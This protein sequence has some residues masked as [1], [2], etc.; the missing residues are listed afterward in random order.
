MKNKRRHRVK[1]AEILSP[2]FQ[3][4][5][6]VMKEMREYTNRYFSAKLLKERDLWEAIKNPSLIM[7][8]GE[9][10]VFNSP[11][12]ENIISDKE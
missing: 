3:R 9:P 6:D 4:M 2:E 10:I 11:A 1:K 8:I 5:Y 12:H 7:K